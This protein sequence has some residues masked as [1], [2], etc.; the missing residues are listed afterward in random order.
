MGRV[1]VGHTGGGDGPNVSYSKENAYEKKKDQEKR[2]TKGRGTN[3][4][5]SLLT[6]NISFFHFLFY[7]PYIYKILQFKV[8]IM[9]L[10]K[11]N[12]EET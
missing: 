8:G 7:L 5:R 10:K 1:G 2:W 3:G 11:V 9:R 12:S 4:T 6:C